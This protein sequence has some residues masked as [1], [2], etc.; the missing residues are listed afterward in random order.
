[1]GNDPATLNEAA[2]AVNQVLKTIIE[3]AGTTALEDA[4]IT[5]SPWLGLPV[6]KQVFEFIL[7]K[8][9]NMIYQDAADAA[10]KLIIDV[11]VNLEK[12]QVLGAF[13]NLQMAIASGDKNAIDQMSKDLDQVYARLIHSDGSASP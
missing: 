12:S 13:Q 5:E 3:G 8:V 4:L 1:M 10:T 7:D 11:Q 6:I 9:S 2:S